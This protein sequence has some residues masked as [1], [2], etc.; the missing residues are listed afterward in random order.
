[1]GIGNSR[2]NT[3]AR[4]PSSERSGWQS[5]REN[6]GKDLKGFIN[7]RLEKN[8][9]FAWRV[10]DGVVLLVPI[11]QSGPEIRRLYRL[12]DPVSTTIWELLDGRRTVQEIHRALCQEF[13]T[14]AQKAK[15]DLVKFL[16]HLKSIGAVQVATNSAGGKRS[17][18]SMSEQ[19]A[20]SRRVKKPPMEAKVQ[21]P[22]KLSI[23]GLGLSLRWEEPRR[24]N[25]A[26]PLY[27]PFVGEEKDTI[28]FDIHFSGCPSLNGQ[29]L[30]FDG[31]HHWKLYQQESQYL[32]EAF[33][34][35]THTRNMISL[36]NPHFDRA[37]VYVLPGSPESTPPWS[38]SRIMHPLGKWMLV[39]RLAETGGVMV[40]AL[41]IDDGGQGRVFVGPSGSGKST[42]ARFWGRRKGVRILSD[43]HLILRRRGKHFYAYGTPWPGMAARVSQ[44]PVQIRQI[45]LIEHHSKHRLFSE[46]GGILASRLFAQLFL[47][48]WNDRIIES[49]VTLCEQ[50]VQEVDCQR[51]GF[52]KDPSVIEYVRQLKAGGTR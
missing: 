38:I 27:E 43:E 22:L 47:P 33:D 13:D 4:R 34:T 17:T 51:L 7:H 11:K 19:K 16:K 49:G 36:V 42:L 31:E 6:E 29:K 48:R 14:E 52:S 2:L 23:G 24:E 30:I 5:S 32:F 46:S 25:W 15:R 41:G 40:H 45:F 44:A 18:K 10:I 20:K 50:L 28:R 26:H 39:N 9:L 37:E 8:P 21:G 35:S 12:K 3:F 1:M